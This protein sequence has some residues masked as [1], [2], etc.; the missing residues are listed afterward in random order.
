MPVLNGVI[1][2]IF[3]ALLV[4]VS[5]CDDLG[6]A[7]AQ[8]RAS[9]DSLQTFKCDVKFTETNLTSRQE[10]TCIGKYVRSG[11]VIRVTEQNSKRGSVR[12]CYAAGGTV[13]TF[14]RSA[15]YLAAGI[16]GQFED[17]LSR[18]DAWH[19]GLFEPYIPGTVTPVTL[20]KLVQLGT[21]VRTKHETVDGQ[22][23]VVI[24]M[25][26]DTKGKKWSAVVRLDPSKNYLISGMEYRNGSATSGE[27]MTL[28]F[29]VKKFVENK[30]GFFFP[31][32][33]GY[34]VSLNGKEHARQSSVFSN[35]QVN[36]AVNA[37]D[38]RFR[39]PKGVVVNDSVR[40][41]R[42]QVDELGNRTSAETPTQ[43]NAVGGPGIVGTATDPGGQVAPSM[44]E[45]LGWTGWVSSASLLV[46]FACVSLLIYRF[47]AALRAAC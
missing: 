23:C 25:N 44:D 29:A 21:E 4:T 2:V 26:I 28:H 5:P 19:Y 16:R 35:V 31:G 13:K 36:A 45:S 38:L 6:D 1:Q 33:V 30:P 9:I 10:H 40:G 17:D 18:C 39:F 34:T 14:E 37:T 47:I 7:L 42:Y 46:F 8:H 11:N 22:D 24:Q 32:E 15:T 12:E 20:E 43:L 41:T 3:W 27:E